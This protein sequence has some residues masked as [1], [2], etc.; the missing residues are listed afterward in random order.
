M[1]M[2]ASRKQPSNGSANRSSR[3]RLP[4]PGCPEPV[5]TWPA[6]TSSS[7]N[8]NWPANGSN[9]IRN[10]PS[11]TV[12]CCGRACCGPKNRT[13]ET[14]AALRGQELNCLGDKFLSLF[15]W[16]HV[17]AAVEDFEAGIGNL[18]GIKLADADR[19]ELV[20]AA[21]EDECGAFDAVEVL[22]QSG[23]VQVGI[24]GDA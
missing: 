4:A 6:A 9:R 21:P 5:T 23:I 17:T 22:W 24:P 19:Q 20:V 18:T 8:P 13:N 2:Q 3:H 10:H 12:I 1:P 14:D 7:G 11:G 16:Q 15:E